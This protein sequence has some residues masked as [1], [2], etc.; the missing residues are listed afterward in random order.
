MNRSDELARALMG[1]ARDDQFALAQLAANPRSPV[2]VLGFHAQQAVEKAIK[3]VLA[4]RSVDFP[5]THDLERLMELVADSRFPIPPDGDALT[6][7]TPFGVTLRY[8]GESH[9]GPERLDPQ[10]AIQVVARTIA[11]AESIL[12]K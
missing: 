6:A 9:P 8:E 1:R 12:G 11:W 10:W 3:A 5:Y 4:G 2:R 7:L